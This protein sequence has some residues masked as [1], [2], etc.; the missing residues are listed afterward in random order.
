MTML[1]RIASHAKRL[2][3]QR[4]DGGERSLALSGQL[5]KVGDELGDGRGRRIDRPQ[6]LLQQDERQVQRIGLA[7]LRV[8]LAF[9]HLEDRLGVV[10]RLVNGE[11]DV[12]VGNAHTGAIYL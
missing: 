6:S 1:F 10:S 2:L 12:L 4:L 3:D 11:R 5:L 8:Y 9:E 7:R